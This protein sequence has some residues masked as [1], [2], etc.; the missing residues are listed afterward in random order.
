MTTITQCDYSLVPASALQLGLQSRMSIVAKFYNSHL[1][2][3][4][5]YVLLI[6][7]K[8]PTLESIC[9]V[10]RRRKTWMLPLCN[11]RCCLP[12]IY[13]RGLPCCQDGSG[14]TDLVP[15]PEQWESCMFSGLPTIFP[16]ELPNT[17]IK[18]GIQW[19]RSD[20]SQ[21][22]STEEPFVLVYLTFC[23]LL[24]KSTLEIKSILLQSP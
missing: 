18:S 17:L 21:D 23:W 9:T 14:H 12:W 20:F 2:P 15:V 8:L 24:L 11:K 10:S 4:S 13:S 19:T 6:I 22:W 5:A 7:H 3:F 16:P 1:N